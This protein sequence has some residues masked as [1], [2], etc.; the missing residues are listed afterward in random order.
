MIDSLPLLPSIPP[1]DQKSPYRVR[2]VPGARAKSIR[3]NCARRRRAQGPQGL[4]LAAVVTGMSTAAGTALV[5]GEFLRLL[6]AA[7]V[8]E[9][10]PFL[11]RCLRLRDI[12]RLARRRLPRGVH[13]V[14]FAVADRPSADGTTRA[15]YQLAV[16]ADV[17]GFKAR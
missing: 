14:D 3:R 9:L 2:V 8:A 7:R 16:P 15:R 6:N 11:L 5:G 17:D 12:R 13:F 10:Y 4:E 1:G